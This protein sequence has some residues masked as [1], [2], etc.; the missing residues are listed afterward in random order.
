MESGNKNKNKDK[1][2]KKED[3]ESDDPFSKAENEYRKKMHKIQII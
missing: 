3:E 2:N 1:K